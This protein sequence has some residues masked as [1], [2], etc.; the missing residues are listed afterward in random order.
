M[1]KK[2]GD[3]VYDAAL[4]HVKNNVTQMILCDAEPADRAAALA[5]AL[6]SVAMVSGDVTVSDGA[7]SGRRLTVAAKSGQSATATGNYNHTCLISATGLLLVTTAGTARS[8]QSG[9]SVDIPAWN[10]ELRDPQ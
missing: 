6:V 9:D 5:S 8:L 1:G 3:E 7:V 4:N 10:Y 2:T